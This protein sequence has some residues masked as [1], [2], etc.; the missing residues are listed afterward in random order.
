M[1]DILDTLQDSRACARLAG[2]EK[3]IEAQHARCNLRAGRI[4]L[5]LEQGQL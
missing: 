5:L 4:E 1:K 3:R 2:C